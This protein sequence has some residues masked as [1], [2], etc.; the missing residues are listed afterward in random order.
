LGPS[1]IGAVARRG[2]DDD[3]V[4][5]VMGSEGVEIGRLEAIGASLDDAVA[6]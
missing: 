2:H 1:R 5:H 6:V 3:A 4:V